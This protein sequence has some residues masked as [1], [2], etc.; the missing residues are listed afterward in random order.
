MAKI[1]PESHM[2]EEV[3]RWRQ[4]AYQARKPLSAEERAK[5]DRAAIEALGL[6]SLRSISPEDSAK[7]TPP[8]RKAS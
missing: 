5:H 2:L 6:S 1:K 4:E 7:Y 8:A 3:R